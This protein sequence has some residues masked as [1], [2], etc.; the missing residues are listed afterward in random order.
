MSRCIA[1]ESG[2]SVSDDHTSHLLSSSVLR[3][4]FPAELSVWSVCWTVVRHG[5]HCTARI[6]STS[7]SVEWTIELPRSEWF[8]WFYR[9]LPA[10]LHEPFR[11]IESEHITNRWDTSE[12]DPNQIRWKPFNIPSA[13]DEKIDFLD[14]SYWIERIDSVHADSYRV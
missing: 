13:D 7:V 9:I 3:S 1:K 11:S 4:E 12:P 2:R 6:E 14:V 8:R 5:I 10:V